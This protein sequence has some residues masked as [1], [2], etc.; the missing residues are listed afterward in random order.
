MR[1]YLLLIIGF[2]GI[3][4]NRCD[5]TQRDINQILLSQEKGYFYHS[6]YRLQLL[7]QKNPENP[8]IQAHLGNILTLESLGLG[9]GL[10]LM[11]EALLSKKIDLKTKKFL[12]EELYFLYFNLQKLE[13]LRESGYTENC[14]SNDVQQK[15]FFAI[16]LGLKTLNDSQ[17]KINREINRQDEE[18]D[19]QFYYLTLS[20]LRA[21]QVKPTK[22]NLDTMK[23]AILKIKKPELQC[24]V[25]KLCEVFANEQ[26]K[27]LNYEW[28]Q[29]REKEWQQCQKQFIGSIAIQR[30]IPT[31]L[32]KSK[33]YRDQKSAD[34][35]FDD[36][37]ERLY[38]LNSPEFEE[39]YRV[40][41]IIKNQGEDVRS[42]EK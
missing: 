38:Y 29:F 28:Y 35:L 8:L 7:Y 37:Y 5:F 42:D 30:T 2:I 27:S 17:R 26:V 12:C 15:E 1:K 36:Y 22:K 6:F 40:S 18:E 4:N 13:F 23:A 34:F 33:K 25:L 9:T 31:T 14:T 41:D 39:P 11:N 32:P 19:L 21:T 20:L 3:I 10:Q 24:R 16:N